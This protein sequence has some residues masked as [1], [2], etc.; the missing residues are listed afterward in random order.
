MPYFLFYP[1]AS[2]TPISQ[3]LNLTRRHTSYP[4][5]GGPHTHHTPPLYALYN[6]LLLRKKNCMP[7][8]FSFF[9]SFKTFLFSFRRRDRERELSSKCV[10]AKG[11]S[12]S[13]CLT[14]QKS[15]SYY[16]QNSYYPPFLALILP[17]SS[18]L[19]TSSITSK[20][21]LKSLTAL[22]FEI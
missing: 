22:K 10:R 19:V 15:S 5:K 2:A 21:S 8:H 13:S 4:D 16:I 11:Q 9:L 18:M 20:V 17:T 7:A 12:S 1:T 14:S 3:S 6:P